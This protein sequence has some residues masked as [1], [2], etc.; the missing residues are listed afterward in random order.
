MSALPKSP[1]PR[2]P[3]RLMNLAIGHEYDGAAGMVA[4]PLPETAAACRRFGLRLA[5]HESGLALHVL[6]G[7]AFD[8]DAARLKA[9]LGSVTLCWQLR[10]TSPD[11]FSVTGL[12]LSTARECLVLRPGTTREHG[13]LLTRGRT[14]ARGDVLPRRPLRFDHVIEPASAPA[15][16]PLSASSAAA[17]QAAPRVI[18]IDHS[19]TGSGVYRLDPNA[20]QSPEWF[21]DERGTWDCGCA[22]VLVLPGPSL[23]SAV[24]PALSGSAPTFATTLPAREVIWRYHF[25]NAEADTPLAIE[26]YDEDTEAA[27]PEQPD[28]GTFALLA[29]PSAP[30]AAKS[31]EFTRPMKLTRRPECAF[32][33]RRGDAARLQPLPK[34]GLS[35]GRAPGSDV[36]RADIFV[37]L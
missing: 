14:A 11:F 37:H 9:A 4:T 24:E 5:P 1:L 22:I 33:L 35:F 26:R 17:T 13:N 27:L 7:R 30:G 3:W 25:F 31:Y 6:S 12:D 2:R 10:P 19:A 36:L 34:A 8:H 18:A 20:P 23:A 15:A 16:R 32:G 29:T 21:A 28:A